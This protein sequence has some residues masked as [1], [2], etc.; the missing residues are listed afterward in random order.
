MPLRIALV[1]SLTIAACIA[2]P[3]TV[4][5]VS[6]AAGGEHSASAEDPDPGEPVPI[7]QPARA[8]GAPVGAELS[9]AGF[10]ASYDAG[11]IGATPK[12]SRASLA[13]FI[14]AGLMPAFLMMMRPS[15]R[16]R[17]EPGD[18]VD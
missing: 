13:M 4:N 16:R 12:L 14:I 15:H 8:G 11:Y 2:V 5:A 9:A 6:P 10:H 18:P 1:A 17:S 3:F 7:R